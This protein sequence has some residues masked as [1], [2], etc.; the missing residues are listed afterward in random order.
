MTKRRVSSLTCALLLAAPCVPQALSFQTQDTPAGRPSSRPAS[1]DEVLW[2]EICQLDREMPG[3]ESYAARLELLLRRRR[4]LLEKVRQYLT[5][6]P[7]GARRDEV[8]RL[9]LRALFEIGTLLGGAYEPLCRRVDAYLRRPPSEAA[10]HEAAYWAIHCRRLDSTSAASQPASA[11][12]ARHDRE[13]LAAYREYVEQHPR[14]RYVPRMA[15]VLFDA[16]ADH[17]D[18]LE[19]RRLVGQLR[20]CFPDHVATASLAARLRCSEAVGQPFSLTFE[21]PGDGQVNTAQWRGQPVLIVVWAGF[22]PEARACV[23]KIE[24]F[25]LD[26]PEVRVVG[27]N[28]DD[29]EQQMRAVCRELGLNWPQFNDGRGWANR[30]ALQWGVRKIPWVFVVD[31]AGRLVGSCG[32]GGWPAL[33]AAAVEN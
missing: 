3:E 30:F 22:I 27:V 23:A 2:Q 5:T 26:H 24:A 8:V 18:V 29:S 17:Q 9:E 21:T 14:S 7:G 28:L 11:P 33:V 20:R 15:T 32:A 4:A 13:L 6:Y 31:R 19:M 12:A 16:A 25:R 10:L 1:P